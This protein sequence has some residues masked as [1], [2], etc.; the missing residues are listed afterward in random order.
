MQYNTSDTVT[1]QVNITPTATFTRDYL[2]ALTW[3]YKGVKINPGSRY[4]RRTVSL[5]SST[6]TLTITRARRSDA[7]VYHV[8]FA[9]LRIYP[10]NQLC[11]E[12][13]LAILRHYPVL[14]PV[15]FHV[16]TDGKYEVARLNSSKEH[17]NKVFTCVYFILQ[18]IHLTILLKSAISIEA[19]SE[20]LQAAKPFLTQFLKSLPLV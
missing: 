10:Y 6:T 20:L 17:T 14:S 13:T 19:I 16:Y 7:G 3:Y 1:L 11:E 8:Q 5:S 15:V 18:E 2:R 9:G 12:E 4:S